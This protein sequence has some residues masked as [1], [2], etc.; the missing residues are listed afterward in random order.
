MA[1]TSAKL[2]TTN[3]VFELPSRLTI[4]TYEECEANLQSYQ[5]NYQNFKGGDISTFIYC[6]LPRVSNEALTS[7]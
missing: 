1:D 5:A 2:S 7:G 6:K 3:G 4:K